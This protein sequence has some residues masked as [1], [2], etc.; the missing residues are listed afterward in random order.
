LAKNVLG[1][2]RVRTRDRARLPP[3]GGQ[4][5]AAKQR[6]ELAGR[7]AYVQA[8]GA[9]GLKG[10]GECMLPDVSGQRTQRGQQQRSQAEGWES[11]ALAPPVRRYCRAAKGPP[12][13]GRGGLPLPGLI[14]LPPFT[15][16]RGGEGTQGQRDVNRC[17]MLPAGSSS[18]SRGAGR[19]TRKPA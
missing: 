2:M 1:S 6:A 19:Q 14:A 16:G 18:S 15:A 17:L 9:A 8:G 11:E 10:L 4:N 3:A 5:K 7:Q 13:G 12:P